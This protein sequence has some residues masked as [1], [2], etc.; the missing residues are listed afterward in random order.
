MPS[1]STDHSLR[2][3]IIV[4]VPVTGCSC[5]VLY[6]FIVSAVFRMRIVSVSSWGIYGPH[7]NF[8]RR[9]HRGYLI[10]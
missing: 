10:K 6:N 3:N 5:I 8:L 7:L 4:Y 2:Y 1:E 9:N